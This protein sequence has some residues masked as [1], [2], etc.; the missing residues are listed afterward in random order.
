PWSARVVVDAWKLQPWAVLGRLGYALA[1]SGRLEQGRGF[2]EEV[3]RAVATTMSS[4]RVGR[5]MQLAWLGEALLLEGRVD[6][7]ERRAHE[8]LSLAQRHASP[9]CPLSFPSRQA[10]AEGAPAGAS[11]TAS[12]RRGD[13]VPRDGYASLAGPGW[14][15]AA[16]VGV[17]SSP[18]S[19]SVLFRR[20]T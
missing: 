4:M 10:A 16:D 14:R 3:V 15:R 1:L 19:S 5:A 20:R 7:A 17:S 11:S 12:D 9:R 6:D 2:L 8:A 18:V 13:D